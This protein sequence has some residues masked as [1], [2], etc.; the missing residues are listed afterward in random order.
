MVS[1]ILR[2]SSDERQVL[3]E[4]VCKAAIS[5]GRLAVI[6]CGDE[7]LRTAALGTLFRLEPDT[8]Q[9]RI[10]TG[11]SASNGMGWSPEGDTYYLVDSDPG[12]V[13]S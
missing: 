12:V 1:E 2:L 8:S 11:L 9:A 5:E 13:W 10:V 7:S 6:R 3:A 4:R